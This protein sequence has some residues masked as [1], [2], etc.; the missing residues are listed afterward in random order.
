[1]NHTV[2][3]SFLEVQTE[4]PVLSVNSWLQPWVSECLVSGELMTN[5]CSDDRND[6]GLGTLVP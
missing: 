3:E 6:T 5:R 4:T 1:V 2:V